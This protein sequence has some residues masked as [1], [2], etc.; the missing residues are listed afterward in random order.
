MR[1]LINGH[2]PE[3][4]GDDMLKVVTS[5][6][7]R[8]GCPRLSERTG[9]RAIYW[10]ADLRGGSLLS[11]TIVRPKPL[12]GCGTPRSNRIFAPS[13]QWVEYDKGAAPSIF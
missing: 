10:K 7:D 5:V 11:E 13:E 6:K 8:V 4:V 9:R 3:V 1:Q 2:S 12:S